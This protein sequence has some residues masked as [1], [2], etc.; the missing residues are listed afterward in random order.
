LSG[1]CL[2]LL[3]ACQPDNLRTPLEHD[4]TAPGPVR[5]VQVQNLNGAA[6][7][8]YSLPSD[9]D[10]L[11]VQADYE[12]R[13]GVKLQSVASSYG[14]SLLLQGFQDT[15]A[16]KVEIYTV[17]KSN[18]RSETLTITVNPLISPVRLT[19]DSLSYSP[20]FGGL[21]IDF[22]NPSQSDVVIILM[23][24]DAITG[25]WSTYDKYYTKAAAGP[26]IESG[27]SNVPTTFGIFV[28][29]RWDNHSDT[30]IQVLTPLLEQ[31]LNTTGQLSI[32]ELPGDNTSKSTWPVAA[33]FTY[34]GDHKIGNGY[35]NYANE[36]L[37]QTITIDLGGKAKLSRIRTWQIDGKR[38]YQESN[39]KDF[40]LWGSNDPNPNGFY[41]ASWELL[42][43]YTVTKPSGLP[44]G[45]VS[46]LDIA[47][48]ATGDEFVL[49][50][51]SPAVRYLRIKILSTFTT[52]EG[53]A[54]LVW[55][56]GFNA[57]GQYQP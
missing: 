20:Y 22:K 53:S 57:W 52:P 9:E 41:D 7:I 18:N 11:K 4:H 44:Y 29:D 31:D 13:P 34:R 46:D 15:G 39:V 21:L 10:L 32:H 25:E 5:N 51:S 27:L 30:M 1:T 47:T 37:P 33:M 45:Q 56:T 54:G 40:E 23:T 26:Y 8:D 36:T 2:L 3:S 28:Q 55:L 49:S 17:D 19:Y 12:I 35:A 16:H 42:G 48:A 38:V 43:S 14:H 6:K 50:P 24:K